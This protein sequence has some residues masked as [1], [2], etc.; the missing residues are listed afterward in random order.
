MTQKRKCPTK[1]CGGELQL[2]SETE[3]TCDNVRT[4]G[5]PDCA[6]T[7]TKTTPHAGFELQR[8]KDAAGKPAASGDASAA[9]KKTT[10]R[11]RTRK[12]K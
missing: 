8:S 4:L 3:T 12:K 7:E 11:K 5:C 2:L 6:C 10:P 9:K 1:G